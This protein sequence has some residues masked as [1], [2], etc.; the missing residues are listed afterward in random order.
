MRDSGGGFY[1]AE[2]ADSDDPYEPGRHGEGAFYLWTEK[3]IVTTV[4]AADANIFNYCYGVRFDGNAPADPQHEF[5][6]RNILY[7]AHTPAEAAERFKLDLPQV[8]AALERAR[9]KLLAR[10]ATRTRPHL[11]DKILTA[12]NGLMIGALARGGAVLGDPG[13]V[14]AARQAADFLYAN[15][16]ERQTR[17]LLRRYRGGAAGIAGQLDDYTFLVS[18]LLD[19]YSAV[20]Q[21]RYLTWAVELTRSQIRLFHDPQH[22]GFFDS[23]ADPTVAV[24]MKGD[25]DGA[26]PA[27]N[28]V[29]AENLVRLGRLTGN[30][31]WLELA[32]QTIK[33]FSS[34]INHYPQALVRMLDARRDLKAK[35]RQLVIA[36]SRDAAGTRAM[37]AAA[38][39][40][41]NPGLLLLLADGAE[42]QEV[43]AG[44]LP[45]IRTAVMQ[46]GK[47]T[48]YLC[49][50]FTCRLP[51]TSTRSLRRELEHAAPSAATTREEQE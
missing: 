19:L 44:Y 50:D 10:R 3:D 18:G 7:L 40:V 36:G 9:E 13:L 51:T 45:F 15:L 17:T 14:E 16:Y 47:A 33:S 35:P 29:A 41:Y 46:D 8:E 5:T 4:G 2:D 37:M 6:G 38:F 43:L 1:S 12:W 32:A 34:Q 30:E 24:R 26:E 39:G 48:A 25:Y 11:D 42:N 20:Q 27:A 23:P 28:S 22:G 21:P 49:E 31:Q